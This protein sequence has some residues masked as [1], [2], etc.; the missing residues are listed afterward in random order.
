MY[1][2]VVVVVVI[3]GAVAPVLPIRVT[4]QPFCVMGLGSTQFDVVRRGRAVRMHSVPG[5]WFR[6]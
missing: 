1:A 3:V 2:C 4:D 5:E 6:K